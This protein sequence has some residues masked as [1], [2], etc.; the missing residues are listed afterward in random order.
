[1]AQAGM[2]GDAISIKAYAGGRGEPVRSL[3]VPGTVF[4]Q[5]AA[6]GP[7]GFWIT[8]G[9]DFVYRVGAE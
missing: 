9:H 5:A 2:K 7:E 4:V 6:A 8:T 3:E 1:M